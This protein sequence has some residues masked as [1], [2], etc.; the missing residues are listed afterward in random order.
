MSSQVSE[1]F[2]SS[3]V[4]LIF[5][6]DDNAII[7]P[8][9]KHNLSSIPCFALHLWRKKRCFY[10]WDI[11]LL[12][13]LH[14][15]ASKM[16]ANRGSGPKRPIVIAKLTFYIDIFLVHHIEFTGKHGPIYTVYWNSVWFNLDELPQR[17][18]RHHWAKW[19]GSIIT[20]PVT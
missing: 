14:P 16:A 4:W 10:V 18:N 5:S 20:N 8:P 19:K 17:V 12:L 6:C 2:V 1:M 9:V 13:C 3:S 7:F 15:V 11:S